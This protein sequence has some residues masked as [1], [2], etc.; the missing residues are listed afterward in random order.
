MHHIISPLSAI[1]CTFTAII[2][3]ESST[4]V[5]TGNVFT[6]QAYS[7]IETHDY[8]TKQGTIKLMMKNSFITIS[9][10]TFDLSG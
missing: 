1:A 7:L 10:N 6:N 8:Y 3:N 4:E 2:D 9:E 5:L